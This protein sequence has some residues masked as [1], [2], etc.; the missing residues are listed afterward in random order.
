M[1]CRASRPKSKS[2]LPYRV[3]VDRALLDLGQ[4]RLRQPR[5]QLGHSCA[6]LA[7]GG[8]EGEV[9]LGRSDCRGLDEVGL[10]A[11]DDYLCLFVGVVVDFSEPG[12]DGGEALGVV[13]VVDEDDADGVLVVGAR[14]GA[15][16]LLAGL[17]ERGST[18]SQICI[19]M[20]LSRRAIFLVANSTPMVGL[21]SGT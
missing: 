21:L 16:G 6:G 17:R 1:G 15:E 12:V 3:D 20:T 14:D 5:E 10:V 9:G 8:V 7:R 11:D 13:E 4:H 18:V 2:H 19:L